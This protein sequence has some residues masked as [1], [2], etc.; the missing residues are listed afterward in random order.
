MSVPVSNYLDELAWRGFVQ[1]TTPGVDDYLAGT[2]ATLYNGADPSAD[3]LHV[4]HLV[5]LMMLKHGQAHGHQPIVLIGGATGMIGDP[6]GK[7]AERNLLSAEAIAHNVAQISKQ[8]DHIFAEESAKPA[9]VVNNLD[10][11]KKFDLI[12]FLRDVG[13]YFSI[14][15]MLTRESVKTRLE[16][17]R[18]D[19]TAGMSFTEFTYQIL[20]AYDFLEL[21]KRH[22]CRVQVGGSDQWGNIV[23]GTDLIRRVTGVEAYGIVCPLLKKKDGGKFG[24]TESGTV[25]IDP[26]RTSPY[27][28]YQ[29]WLNS[30]DEEV[31]PRLK[32]FTRLPREEIN[33]LERDHQDR[34]HE[35]AAQRKLAETLTRWIHGSQAL[36]SAIQASKALFGG[37]LKALDAE[38]LADVFDSVPSAEIPRDRFVQGVGL[39]DL[40]VETKAMP[41]KGEARRRIQGGG[42][43][44]NG[45]KVSDF[46]QTVSAADILAERFVVL[47]AGKKSYTLV[48]IV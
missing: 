37:E 23:G 9:M 6:S 25:W 21:Q 15:V 14:N 44:L 26:A 30:D 1:D 16:R 3:S 17:A 38:T 10:W 41:S 28:F 20:Q 35:R 8:V 27:K 34:P 19:K 2:S 12:D 48:K 42:V 13:K 32:I 47:R 11:M 22:D 24:K 29:F 40:L 4:G 5:P 18:D 39:M 45:E 46:E 7:S 31:I 33:A 36:D 43:Y